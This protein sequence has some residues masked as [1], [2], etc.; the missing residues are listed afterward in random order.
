MRNPFDLTEL[1]NA[2]EE[3]QAHIDI[4]AYQ[5]HDGNRSLL[6]NENRRGD[7]LKDRFIGAIDQ[8]TTSSRFI[9]FD[10]TGV[11]V[12][13]YQTE[14]RQIHEHSGAVFAAS[15][16]VINHSLVPSFR[17]HEHDPL[18]LVDSVFTCIEE[19]MKTFMALGHS[20]SDIEA[21]GITSQRETTLCWDWETGEPLHNA[22]AWPDTRTKNLV[23]ELKGQEGADELPA[24]CGLPLSTYPSSVSLVWLL[25]HI[26][27]VKQAYDEGRLAFGTV[28]S[29]LLYNLNGGP[30]AGRHVTDV[31]N[32]SRT[33][34]MNLETLQY[35]DKLLKFFGIDRKKIK[36]P[37]ILPSSDPEGYGYVRFG[38]LDGVP[39]TSCLGDQSAALVGHC[40]FT[41]GTAKNTYGTG[42]FLLY[43]V[44]EKPVIS[45]H[46]LL[47]TVGFQLGKDRKPVYALE[48]SVAVAGSG[49]SFL[50]NNLGFFRDSRKVSDL[51][52]TVPDSGGC[53]F[54]TAFS[55]LFAPYWIDD[56][57][58]TI[59][60]I[61][62]HTQRGHIARATMEAAC[63]QTKA[64]LDAMAR[65]SGHK[66]SELAVDGGMSNSDICMQTQAD[67][68]QIPVERPA[69]HETT[70]LGAAI[71]AG[72]AIDVWREFSELKNMNRANRTTFTPRISPAQ[73]ARMYKQW[74]KA[75]EM[76]RGWLDTSEIESEGQ[77]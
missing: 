26:P 41:P 32:A 47:A 22:I 69:M 43:N 23:R 56:A 38:P 9:I 53:V 3:Q 58:G 77:E 20:K 10:C 35:D 24:I 55:G 15:R 2:V 28:D 31:T 29:W 70:A 60:G 59:F 66:L 17:W 4:S 25:R 8:G 40:A 49:I 13:K 73:S 75:V 64:I 27:K 62:Q 44:G 57:K 5:S 42:C 6:Q 74:S 48:G 71:A 65:D 36:L 52:A 33:M 39:I 46:G 67:I 76:S 30:E 12:A 14:F 37:K 63:F 68:I 19:A 18:E 21:I 11:P 51:A 16:I 7:N 72:F 34:F 45:K 1:D 54:V 61:T 50:M